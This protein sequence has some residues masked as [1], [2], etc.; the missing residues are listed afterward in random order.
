MRNPKWH[1]DEVILALDL[2]FKTEP[3]QIHARN[4]EVV[5]GLQ[6]IFMEMDVTMQDVFQIPGVVTK[7]LDK[8]EKFIIVKIL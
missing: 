5:A 3:G 7:E 8:V 2:Y 6:S 1:R 4:P